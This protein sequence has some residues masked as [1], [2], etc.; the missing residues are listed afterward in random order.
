MPSEKRKSTSNNPEKEKKAKVESE[1]VN[2]DS[3]SPIAKP[4]ANK[5]LNKK[6]QKCIK[7][8]AK[9]RNLKRGVKEVV[10]GINKGEKG[11][12]LFI[13]DFHSSHKLTVL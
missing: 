5:K 9:T 13:T 12:V 8:A 3:L 2:L 4:L 10:K 11:C 7:R 6:I 1:D